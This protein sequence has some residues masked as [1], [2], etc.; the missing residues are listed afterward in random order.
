MNSNER[1]KKIKET[2]I[3][4][5]GY[6]VTNEQKIKISDSLKNLKYHS[7]VS[8]EICQYDLNNNKIREYPSIRNAEL[9]NKLSRGYLSFKL[10]NNNICKY[11]NYI[12]K[13]K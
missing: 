13:L 9:I 3:K 12:W 8:M 1:I 7:A 5:G 4:N 10:K 6:I 11:K 2:R